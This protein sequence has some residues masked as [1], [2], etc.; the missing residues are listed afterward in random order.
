VTNLLSIAFI[1]L[2]FILLIW[3]ANLADAH[4]TTESSTPSLTRVS[5]LLLGLFYG[6]TLLIGLLLLAGGLASEQLD[7]QT[8]WAGDLGQTGM[9]PRLVASIFQ[10]LPVIG[11]GVAVA[12]ALGLFLLLPPARRTLAT[13]IP[14]DP[15]STVHAV[16]LSLTMIIVINMVVTLGIGLD[17]LVELMLARPPDEEPMALTL[18][19]ATLWVQQILMAVWALIG[20]GWL[21]RRTLAAT[22]QRLAIVIPRGRDVLA[23]VGVG[24][25]TV[26]VSSIV[27]AIA[28]QFDIGIDPD[29][30]ALN[31]VLLGPLFTSVFGV[32]TVGLA[33][34]LGEETLFRGALQPRFGLIFT[35]ILFAIVHSNYGISVSTLVV[36][37]AGLIFGILRNRFNTTTAMMAHATYNSTL[38]FLAMLAVQLMENPD[39][40]IG[41]VL[42]PIVYLVYLF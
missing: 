40:D 19:L 37:V 10:S 26:F 8:L 2:P 24:F 3:I 25:G 42:Y 31:E 23:G 34:A 15:T 22:L 38:A 29:V 17:T 36:F 33:A 4:R 1:F 16:A 21:S 20:V 27:A 32:L 18:P 12:S 5:Y 7:L 39:F 6:A 35:T 30:E 11:A 41:I 14:I 9:D 28:A 13:L